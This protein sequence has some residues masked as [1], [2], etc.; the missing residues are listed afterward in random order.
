ME[1]FA[2]FP[3]T[4]YSFDT[5]NNDYKAVVNIMDRVTMLPVLLQQGL[6]FYP[7]S[8]QEGDKAEIIAHKYYGDTKRH[9]I[10]MF[11]NQIID[12]WNDFSLSLIDFQNS[13]NVAYGSMANAQAQLHHVEQVTTII[14]VSANGMTTTDVDTAVMANNYTYNF[15][16]GTIQTVTFPNIAF[17]TITQSNNSYTTADGSAVYITVILQAVSNFTYQQ[18]LNEAKRNINLVDKSYADTIE[19][20]LQQLLAQ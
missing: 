2:Q 3:T 1:Y 7:Y 8:F 16:N 4:L 17:P 20:Q 19:Q 14:T 11:A 15:N 10:V 13:I 5:A 9:W 18:R 12:P 6:V